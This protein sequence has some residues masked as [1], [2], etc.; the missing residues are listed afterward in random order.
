M[1]MAHAGAVTAHMVLLVVV[2]LLPV[3]LLRILMLVFVIHIHLHV[4]LMASPIHHHLLRL[5][6]PLTVHAVWIVRCGL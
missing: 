2:I 5:R 3:M 6:M 1:L 4:T